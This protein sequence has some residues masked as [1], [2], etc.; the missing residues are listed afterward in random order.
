[1]KT[2][3]SV[4]MHAYA[5]RVVSGSEKP[6]SVRRRSRLAESTGPQL[7][8]KRATKHAGGTPSAQ[9]TWAH[10]FRGQRSETFVSNTASSATLAVLYSL[11][12]GAEPTRLFC[13]R[14]SAGIPQGYWA[15]PPL[16][17]LQVCR[18]MSMWI[19]MHLLHTS[20][21]LLPRATRT[22]QTP[23]EVTGSRH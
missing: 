10:I 18:K 6:Q 5:S 22:W 12:T 1:M 16:D 2:P 20:N 7:F 4:V 11:H 17:T 19:R 23:V 13:N 8:I 21:T 15:H 9:P 14:V 3:K